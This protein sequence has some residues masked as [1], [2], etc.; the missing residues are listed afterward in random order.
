MAAVPAL[1]D[2][3]AGLAD[4]PARAMRAR[5]DVLTAPRPPFAGLALDRP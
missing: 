2:W 5:L 1:L 3:I 4:E